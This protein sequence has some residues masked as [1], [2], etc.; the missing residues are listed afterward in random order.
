M[1]SPCADYL[2]TR[3]S[4]AKRYHLD[5]HC[6]RTSYPAAAG[7]REREFVAARSRQAQ[8]KQDA[9]YLYLRLRLGKQNGLAWPRKRAIPTPTGRIPIYY[10]RSP[11]TLSDC[12]CSPTSPPGCAHGVHSGHSDQPEHERRSFVFFERPQKRPTSKGRS[13]S[14]TR[15]STTKA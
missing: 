11:A 15:P 1:L 9:V 10:H 4:G 2:P 13:T 5:R 7:Q 6:Q 12:P 8:R 3:A 14:A